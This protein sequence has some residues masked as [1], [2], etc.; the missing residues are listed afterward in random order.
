VIREAQSVV[1]SLAPDLPLFS[2]QTMEEGLDTLNGFLLF[3]LGAGIAAALGLLG[4]ILAMVGVYGVISYSTSQR[5]HEIGIRVA[6]GA[7]QSEILKMILGQG[8]VIV[9]TGLIVGC[10]AAFAF[11]RL[12]GNFLVGVGPADPATYSIVTIVL[13]LVALLACYIPAR[14]AMRVDPMVAL[15]Y[16]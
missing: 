1:R 12:I 8:L 2:V 15:R 5:T 3:Q 13:G 9:F 14:R 6:L 4:L 11:A 7:Q 10:A 16:E